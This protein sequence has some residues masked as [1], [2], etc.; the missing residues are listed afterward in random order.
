[1]PYNKKVVAICGRAQSGKSTLAEMMEA[2]ADYDI[3]SFA[4]PI[5]NMLMVMGRDLGMFE[6]HLYGTNESKNEPLDVLGGKSA[7]FAMQTL[8]TEWRELIDKNLWVNHMDMRL[9]RSKMNR[10]VIDD[11]RFQHEYRHL[12]NNGVLVIGIERP[13]QGAG[14]K[15]TPP[16]GWSEKFQ[17]FKNKILNRA[18]APDAHAS[19]QWDFKSTGMPIIQ[20]DG[21]LEELWVKVQAYL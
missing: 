21:T 9:K 4:D 11:T 8:G 18:Q 19:E 7:R 3:M 17:W 13:G 5:K 2:K 6:R 16:Q 10:I 12:I 1:M 14:L 15:K 20:N